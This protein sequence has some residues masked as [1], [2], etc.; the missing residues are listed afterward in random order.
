MRELF[1]HSAWLQLTLMG[2]LLPAEFQRVCC[3]PGGYLFGKSRTTV[4]LCFVS[5]LSLQDLS[6]L[7][8]AWSR[9]QWRHIPTETYDSIEQTDLSYLLRSNETTEMR[10]RPHPHSSPVAVHATGRSSLNH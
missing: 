2:N 9:V 4:C 8:A 5:V 1:H 10:P 6:R 7:T 3:S